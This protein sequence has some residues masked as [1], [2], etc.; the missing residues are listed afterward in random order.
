MTRSGGAGP[1][2]LAHLRSGLFWLGFAPSTILFAL[3]APFLWPCSFH[4][5]RRYLYGWT[6]FN[7]WWLG[8][9]CGLRHRVVG[10]EHLVG[11]PAMVMAK[12]ESTWETIVLQGILPPQVWV[13]KRELLRIPFFGWGMALLD[14]I[15][16][17]REAGRKA[18]AQMLR[19]GKERL[20]R[21]LWLVVFPEGTRVAPGERG[22]YKIG[23]AILA[24]REG[25]RVVPAAHNAGDFWPRHSFVKRP[26]TIELRFGPPIETAGREPAVVLAEVEA[27][28]E[29]NCADIRRRTV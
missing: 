28:I 8:V 19:Q 25:V 27:W 9:T 13:L 14:P 26:G 23:G 21:G 29:E 7:V 1:G 15:A 4:A 3:G 22:E 17:D 5:R 16:I 20:A 10:M 11:A 2:F 6:A 24:V 18:L 12:H